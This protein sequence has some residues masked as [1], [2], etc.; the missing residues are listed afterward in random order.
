MVQ[1]PR[2]C[3]RDTV[4]NWLLTPVLIHQVLI[5]QPQTNQHYS[6]LVS[7]QSPSMLREAK[8]IYYIFL[9]FLHKGSNV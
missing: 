7:F 9:V 5:S 8:Q 4:R 6:F 1:K 3:K 2:K